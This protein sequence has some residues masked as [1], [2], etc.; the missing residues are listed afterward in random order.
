M[1]VNSCLTFSAA[2]KKKMKA[3][4]I[5]DIANLHIWKWSA[6]YNISMGAVSVFS[7]NLVALCQKGTCW[8]FRRID[9][10]KGVS[11]LRTHW[12]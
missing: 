4:A 10:A 1:K 12:F 2:K 7:G 3:L 9:S 6:A 5:Q 11:K 8:G